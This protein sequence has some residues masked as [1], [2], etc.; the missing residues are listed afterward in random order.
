LQKLQNNSAI[1]R[2]FSKKQFIRNPALRLPLED[3]QQAAVSSWWQ[4]AT[5]GLA[6]A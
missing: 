3:G 6:V 4:L 1:L 5:D 2:P